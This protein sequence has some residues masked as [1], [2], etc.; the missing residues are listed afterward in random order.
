MRLKNHTIIVFI[1]VSFTLAIFCI[2]YCIDKQ[3]KYKK[4]VEETPAKPNTIQVVDSL[5]RERSEILNV[6]ADEITAELV[7]RAAMLNNM[8]DSIQNSEEYL[9]DMEYYEEINLTFYD[10]ENKLNT[11]YLVGA[12]GVLLGMAFGVWSSIIFHTRRRMEIRMARNDYSGPTI[13]Y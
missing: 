3:H 6:P 2:L 12:L 8:H 10:Q 4:L 7:V 1:I 13:S 11:Q 5:E 9:T